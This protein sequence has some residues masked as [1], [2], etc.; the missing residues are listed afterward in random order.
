MGRAQWESIVATAAKERLVLFQQT[1]AAVLAAGSGETYQ[2]Y[3]N[4]G[5]ILKVVNVY[6]QVNRPVGS[7]S[8]THSLYLAYN[9]AIN[10][11]W[12]TSVFGSELKFDAGHFA[13]ADSLRVPADIAAEAFMLNQIQ[14]DSVVPF[15]LAY[16]N[17]TN[18]AQNNART[19]RVLAI[20]RQVGN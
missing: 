1:L 9:P 11:M 8:G 19:Y 18:V 14:F 5:T 15:N 13:V 6:F 17:D 2:I 4:P 3:A 7:T 20:E 10:L 16:A 12:G